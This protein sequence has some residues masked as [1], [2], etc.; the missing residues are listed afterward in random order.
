M[1][2]KLEARKLEWLGLTIGYRF[3]TDVDSEGQKGGLWEAWDETMNIRVLSRTAHFIGLL[4]SE[5]WHSD[6]VIILFY[7]HP[8]VSQRPLVILFSSNYCSSNCYHWRF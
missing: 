1:E 2:T 3:W 4:V 5:E 7:G 8:D 6:W